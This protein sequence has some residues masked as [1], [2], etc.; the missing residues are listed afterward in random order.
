MEMQPIVASDLGL[1][2]DQLAERLQSGRQT[3]FHNRLHWAKQ[4]MTR[5]GLVE[6]ILPLRRIGLTGL[7]ARLTFQRRF[8]RLLAV[9]PLPRWKAI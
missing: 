3:L 9:S 5:A 2:E 1:T 4:Y 7:T 6:T 8:W